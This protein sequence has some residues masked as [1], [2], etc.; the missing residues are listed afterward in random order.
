MDQLNPTK[1]L[2][3]LKKDSNDLKKE[4]KKDSRLERLTKFYGL[5]QKKCEEKQRG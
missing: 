3:K 2:S 5:R 4:E 1:R